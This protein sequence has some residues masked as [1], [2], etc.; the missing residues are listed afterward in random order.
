[1]TPPRV[2]DARLDSAAAERL[3]AAL[4]AELLE[5]YG[6]PDADPDGLTADDL[7]P[8]TGAFVVVWQD[9][10]AVACGGLRRYDT[11]V[12]ELKRMFVTP[13]MRGRGLSRT[14]LAELETRAGTIGYERLILETG[15]RQPEAMQLY[16]TAGYTPIAP[17]GF[18]RTEPLSRC[19]AK[20]LR[21]GRTGPAGSSDP[22]TPSPR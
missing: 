14:V 2:E 1:M 20:T 19:Y 13:P 21:S 5:R 11:H 16:E 4:G 3:V 10:R 7:A 22:G 6:V 12:G 17:Y 18:Y 15:A 9:D 8:P